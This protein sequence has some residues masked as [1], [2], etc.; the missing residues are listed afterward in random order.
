VVGTTSCKSN[1]VLHVLIGGLTN[2]H[3]CITLEE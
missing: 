1:R 3:A 2:D